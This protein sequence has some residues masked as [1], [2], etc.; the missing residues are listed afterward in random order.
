MATLDW[1]LDLVPAK[2]AW[3]LQSNTETFTSPLNRSMQTVER[4]GARW[5]VTLE[6]PPKND[7][8]R[9][10]LEAFL[11]ALGG[12]AGRFTLWPHAR[13][14]S[15]MYSP[16]V[17]GTMTD[18]KVLPT[19]SWPASTLVLRAGDY[20][21]AGGELKLV[22]ADVTSNGSGLASVPVAP[23]FRKAPANNSAITLDKPRA[24]MM[25]VSD[26]YS[27]AVIPGRIS[28]AVVISAVEMF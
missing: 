21:S 28:D 18:F 25:L 27:V 6:F 12:M 17:N 9:G 1:P 11:A 15:S 2:V 13:P 5:K 26:E 7:A 10:R 16:L 3:G 4:P 19:K 20:L 24:T 14:G 22:T 8:D 23:A